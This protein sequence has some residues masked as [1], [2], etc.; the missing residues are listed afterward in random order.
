M[1]RFLGLGRQRILRGHFDF[2]FF[3][4]SRFIR[5]ARG[6]GGWFWKVP[7]GEGGTFALFRRGD[8]RRESE[9]ERERERER[10]R[11]SCV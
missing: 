1:G 3:F 7:W 4:F 6:G 11:E 8:S 10:N 9:S 5:L 2:L